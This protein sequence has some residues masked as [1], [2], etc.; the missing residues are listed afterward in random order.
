MAEQIGRED[1]D[2]VVGELFSDA[3]IAL[4]QG[5]SPDA[6][7]GRII[8]RG[9]SPEIAS[10]I[11]QKAV[12]FRSKANNREADD[13]RFGSRVTQS[14]RNESGSGDMLVGGLICAVGILITA[15]SYG[16]AAGGGGTYVV[17]WGAILFGAIKF[18]KGVAGR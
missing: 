9:M 14:S 17:A 5:S 8:G 13:S 12:A 18:L 16:S 1:T 7:K 15:A 10:A 11:V 6:V 2:R 3:V 4:Q